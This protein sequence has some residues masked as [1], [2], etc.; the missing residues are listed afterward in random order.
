M[1]CNGLSGNH[2][3]IED[4]LTFNELNYKAIKALEFIDITTTELK[5]HNF[6]LV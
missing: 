1:Y 2:I 3:K 6:N 5:W 4:C